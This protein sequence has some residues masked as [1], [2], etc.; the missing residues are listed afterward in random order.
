MI[1]TLIAL[2]LLTVGLTA[3]ATGFTEGQRIVAEAQHRERAIGAAR[4]KLMERLA[5]GYEHATDLVAPGE[6]ELD[7]SLFG[8]DEDGGVIR[9]W[10]VEPEQPDHGLTRVS[11][12]T[13]WTRRG[14]RQTYRISGLLV[15]GRTP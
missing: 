13:Q 6:Q 7:G 9:R 10:Y 2:F 15:R 8:E 5:L 12:V 11:V 14:E 4:E 3:V 1:E